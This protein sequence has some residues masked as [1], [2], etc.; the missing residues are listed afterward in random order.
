MSASSAIVMDAQ[1]KVWGQSS[2]DQMTSQ[3]TTSS[4]SV[5]ADVPSSTTLQPS[6]R[7]SP[8]SV[9]KSLD[10]EPPVTKA[11]VMPSWADA[12]SD[13]DEDSPVHVR[14]TYC[15]SLVNLP[16]YCTDALTDL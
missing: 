3:S 9:P 8:W 6:S 7:A 15:A 5:K 10:S 2:T 14:T 1:S 4:A 13:E 12:D 11:I 16:S